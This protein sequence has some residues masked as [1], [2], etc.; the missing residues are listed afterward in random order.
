[1]SVVAA[2]SES[3]AFDEPHGCVDHG[4]CSKAMQGA[5]LQTEDVAGQMECI[6][7]APPVREQLVATYGTPKDLINILG[8]LIFTIDFGVFSIREFRADQPETSLTFI[9]R[10]DREPRLHEETHERRFG[11]SG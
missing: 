10:L 5:G 9:D 6:D 3:L 2:C 8:R 4:F 11:L 1:M 7:L